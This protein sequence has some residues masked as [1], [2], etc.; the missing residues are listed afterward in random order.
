M[1]AREA[2]T[3]RVERAEGTVG[4]WDFLRECRV[5]VAASTITELAWNTRCPVI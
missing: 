4:P 5:A 1:A 3:E 2:N